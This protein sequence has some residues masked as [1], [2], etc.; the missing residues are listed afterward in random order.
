MK[1]QKKVKV[2]VGFTNSDLVLK[3]PAGIDRGYICR[4]YDKNE[5]PEKTAYYLNMEMKG[6]EVVFRRLIDKNTNHGIKP[7]DKNQLEKLILP[8]TELKIK[9]EIEVLK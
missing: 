2:Y 6:N 9:I 1:S 8:Y 5:D 4:F 3:Y 7:A